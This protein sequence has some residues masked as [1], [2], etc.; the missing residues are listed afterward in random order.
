VD[1][2][3]ILSY[4]DCT[5]FPT[6]YNVSDSVQPPAGGWGVTVTAGLPSPVLE[7]P[8]ARFRDKQHANG[9]PTPDEVQLESGFEPDEPDKPE[10]PESQG[11]E[12]ES[13]SESVG[14][15][16]TPVKSLCETYATILEVV[17]A[18]PFTS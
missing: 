9:D 4:G 3:S 16:A 14:V 11:H 15:T 1:S 10:E 5:M 7:D 12:R 18:K 17:V 6:L 8:H 2:L 13:Q